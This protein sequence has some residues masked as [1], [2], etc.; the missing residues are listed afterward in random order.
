ML[1]LQSFGFFF[2]SPPDR[3]APESDLC[4]QRANF[5]KKHGTRQLPVPQSRDLH[6]STAT[7][8]KF[9]TL[10]TPDVSRLSI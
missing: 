9:V 7:M 10:M 1:N 4:N 8:T 6:T 2:G 5:S 3:R